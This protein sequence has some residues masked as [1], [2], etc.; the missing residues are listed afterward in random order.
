MG[1]QTENA[2]RKSTGFFSASY[3]NNNRKRKMSPRFLQ[4]VGMHKKAGAEL[5]RLSKGAGKE[6]IGFELGNERQAA[7]FL[8]FSPVMWYT[9]TTGSTI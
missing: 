3:N 2:G 1:E 9:I 6:K 7:Y 4:F 5:C 8:A